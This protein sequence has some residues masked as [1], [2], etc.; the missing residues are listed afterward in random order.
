[1]NPEQKAFVEQFY[2][3]TQGN[4]ETRLEEFLAIQRETPL[5]SSVTISDFAGV[6]AEKIAVEEQRELELQTLTAEHLWKAVREWKPNPLSELPSADPKPIFKLIVSG[7]FGPVPLATGL[8]PPVDSYR[9][10]GLKSSSKDLAICYADGFPS[11]ENP[12]ASINPNTP[13]DQEYKFNARTDPVLRRFISLGY[14]TMMTPHG[15]WA[16]TGHVLV[17]D[18]DHG[19]NCHPWI[20]LAAKWDSDDEELQIGGGETIITAPQTVALNDSYTPGVL[21]GD[22]NRTTIARLDPLHPVSDGRR[23]VDH[24]GPD[25]KFKADR[26]GAEPVSATR[27][28]YGPSLVE[29]M[30]WYWDPVL[31]R[32]VC[33]T[34][35]GRRWYSY[36]KETR[37]YGLP[38]FFNREMAPNTRESEQ[39]PFPQEMIGPADEGSRLSRMT[40]SAVSSSVYKE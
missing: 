22:H 16:M 26:F 19:R 15:G 1:M 4:Y 20:V 27:K 34:K 11:E 13:S 30:V 33:Y 39:R 10:P 7:D 8:G 6:I 9:P 17:L 3:D 31:K 32:E 28:P 36:N 40:G 29:I 23:L 35:D 38:R 12:R 24:F 37:D 25:F 14:I 5:M 21:P 18:A 2:R